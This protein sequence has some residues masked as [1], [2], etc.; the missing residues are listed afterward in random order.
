MGRGMFRRRRTHGTRERI[1]GTVTILIPHVANGFRIHAHD[2]EHIDPAARIRAT[3]SK[4]KHGR[5]R[6][7]VTFGIP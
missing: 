2:I 6:D 5:N 3:N 7:S 1:E 4:N